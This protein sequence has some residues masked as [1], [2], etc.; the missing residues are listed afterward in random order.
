MLIKFT[1][2]FRVFCASPR[3]SSVLQRNDH[4]LFIEGNDLFTSLLSSF[5][6]FD[7]DAMPHLTAKV[8][9]YSPGGRCFTHFSRLTG[10]ETAATTK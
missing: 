10:E 9:C 8:A 2:N 3:I 4:R 1:I 6:H 5:P 7:K